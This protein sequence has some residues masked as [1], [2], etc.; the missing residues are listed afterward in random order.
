MHAKADQVHVPYCG[1]ALSTH[2]HNVRS[3][4]LAI[5]NSSPV[6]TLKKKKENMF[7]VNEAVMAFIF[8]ENP[9]LSYYVNEM[10]SVNINGLESLGNGSAK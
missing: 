9:N 7:A 1:F 3:I 5:C 4:R 10:P 6:F 2:F 8:V